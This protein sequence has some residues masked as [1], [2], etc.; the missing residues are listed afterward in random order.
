MKGNHLTYCQC[1]KHQKSFDFVM[2]ENML[3]NLDFN[4]Y[5]LTYGSHFN[6]IDGVE[7]RLKK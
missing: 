1:F 6:D 7:E 2:C 4:T 5:K 3:T